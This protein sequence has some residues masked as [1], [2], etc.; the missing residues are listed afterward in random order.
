[1]T[2]LDKSAILEKA[3]KNLDTVL[4]ER[5]GSVAMEEEKEDDA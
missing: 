3:L 2:V 5:Q 4:L 1:M